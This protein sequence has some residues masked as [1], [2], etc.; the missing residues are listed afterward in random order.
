MDEEDGQLGIESRLV[1]SKWSFMLAGNL[2][3]G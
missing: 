2:D 1:Q 3:G